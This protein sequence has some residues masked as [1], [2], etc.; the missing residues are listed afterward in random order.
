MFC[1]TESIIQNIPHIQHGYEEYSAYIILS[2]P[3]NIVL[4]SE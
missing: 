4:G 2:I 1:R 3:Q